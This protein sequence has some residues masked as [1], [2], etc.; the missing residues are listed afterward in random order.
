MR[1][2]SIVTHDCELTIKKFSGFDFYAIIK[3]NHD[4][5]RWMQPVDGGNDCIITD[6]IS[7]ACVEG[8]KEE[9][10]GIANAILNGKE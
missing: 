8:N 3:H 5:K 6:R 10:L 9:M 2:L 1:R 7:D 4:T